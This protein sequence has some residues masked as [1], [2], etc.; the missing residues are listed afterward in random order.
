[1][2]FDDVINACAV[3][4]VNDRSRY[5]VQRIDRLTDGSDCMLEFVL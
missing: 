4:K 2:Y 1:M 5:S 3:A